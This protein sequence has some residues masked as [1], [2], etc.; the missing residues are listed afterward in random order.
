MAILPVNI[1]LHAEVP[2]LL[3]STA[4]VFGLFENKDSFVLIVS[5]DR[6]QEVE[7]AFVGQMDAEGDV[8][9]YQEDDRIVLVARIAA[10]PQV[11]ILST[12]KKP[13]QIAFVD[14][15]IAG[16]TWEIETGEGTLPL[17][18]NMYL[19]R[20]DNQEGELIRCS[21]EAESGE[22][23]QFYLPA[24]KQPAEIKINKEKVKVDFDAERKLAAFSFDIEQK[25][26][27]TRKLDGAWKWK[28]EPLCDLAGHEW[29]AYKKWRGLELHEEMEKGYFEYHTTFVA[30]KE[31]SSLTLN[32]T[33]V[34]D[35][36]SV[37]VN[38]QYIGSGRDHFKADIT[39]AVQWGQENEVLM[40]LELWGRWEHGFAE[41]NGIVCPVVLTSKEETIDLVEWRRL[42]VGTYPEP[43]KLDKALPETASEFNDSNW[44]KIEVKKNWDSRIHGTWRGKEYFW[45]RT[46]VMV[47]ESF[48]G[49]HIRLDFGECRDECWVYANGK[50]VRWFNWFRVPGES[51]SV[52]LSEY[53]KPGEENTLAVLVLV[54]WHGQGALHQYMR[55][56][57]CYNLANGDW[58]FTQGLAGEKR[59]YMLPQYQDNDW[60]VLDRA[61]FSKEGDHDIIWLRTTFDLDL[62]DGWVVPLALRIEGF[63]KKVNMY[64]NGYFLGRY[65]SE[66][67]QEKFYMP[68]PWLKSSN[69]Q[70]TL[71]VDGSQAGLQLGELAL[72]SYPLKK[73]LQIDL[74][75]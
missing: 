20:E 70:L 19:L 58:K 5:G 12:D 31:P 37:F 15:K 21:A 50:F 30:P 56:V 62:P 49:K 2:T 63:E 17:L 45:Y 57:A 34:W 71:M 52:D 54:K 66:G 74:Q 53:L 33:R 59:G 26:L 75:L 73:Q 24:V 61:N 60:T 32:F 35:E 16:R 28:T 43:W 55:L 68:E 51:F 48:D 3:Y 10:E 65:R 23:L 25:E 9:I 36:V 47:P 64:L 29:R 39:R 4:E 46:K 40:T 13:I 8:S 72:E 18:S 69:N 27:F 14:K 1:T 44:K 7:M 6:A 67:P 22:K 41:E 11:A 38:G 42:A